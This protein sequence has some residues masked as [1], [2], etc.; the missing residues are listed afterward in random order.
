[1]F[2]IIL[3]LFLFKTKKI[4]FHFLVHYNLKAHVSVFKL[5]YYFITF[6]ILWYVVQQYAELDTS[7]SAQNNLLLTRYLQNGMN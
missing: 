4:I 2:N 6:L 1:M 7:N 5:F 3:K